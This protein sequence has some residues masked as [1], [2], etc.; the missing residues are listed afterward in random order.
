MPLCGVPAVTKRT[1]VR[2]GL[3]FA[4]GR[5][6]HEPSIAHSSRWSATGGGS[7][8]TTRRRSAVTS[9]VPS[10]RASNTLGHACWYAGARL[11]R[12]RLVTRSLV[13]TA[14][15]R[16]VKASRRSPKVWYSSARKCASE[17]CGVVIIRAVSQLRRTFARSH[18]QL[19][20]LKLIEKLRFQLDFVRKGQELC[21]ADFGVIRASEATNELE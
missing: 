7:A 13:S 11:R 18:R 3:V 16:S 12:T 10:L 9:T 1:W 2:S 14:S 15:S 19:S 8:V 5:G 4:S 6:Q 20:K 21:A 17:T